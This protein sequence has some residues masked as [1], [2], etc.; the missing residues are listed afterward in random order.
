MKNLK[1]LI[2][3]LILVGFPFA[4]SIAQESF[5]VK[6]IN[7]V[8]GEPIENT[9]ISL[10]ESATLAVSDKEGEASISFDNLPV[11]FT[12]SHVSFHS[13]D[14]LLQ[15]LPD[16]I[17]LIK[18]VPA[19][20]ALKQVNVTGSRYQ[21]YFEKEIFYVNDFEFDDEVVWVTGYP[22]KNITN[23]QL[24]LVTIEGET[25]YSLET[26]RKPSLRKDAFGNIHLICSDSLYQLFF[27]GE[28]VMMLYGKKNK[29]E[30]HDLFDIKLMLG[31][32]AV[33]VVSNSTGTFR[34]FR[35]INLG[36]KE[37]EVI[38][39]S[40]NREL[41]PSKEK[42]QNYDPGPIPNVSASVG[43]NN[44]WVTL[45]NL[46]ASKP[47][48][49][50]L[51]I[52]EIR[53][54]E[55][56]MGRQYIKR[57]IGRDLTV[58]S[59]N[60]YTNYALD[61]LLTFKPIVAQVFSSGKNFYIFEDA[62]LILWEFDKTYELTDAWRLDVNENARDLS[63]TQDLVNEALYISYEINGIYQIGLLDLETGKITKTVTLDGFAFISNIKVH[64]GRIYFTHQT[65]L[66]HRTMNLYSTAY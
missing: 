4:N 21:E 49:Q 53:E 14:V 63:L 46:K 41:F 22:G 29:P 56:D 35:G 36:D 44:E 51:S 17:L 16:E 58:M 3:L 11:V 62:E 19:T 39:C 42:A 2:V 32:T 28:S 47:E 65:P 1:Y 34:E 61:R 18:L 57:S 54:K 12:V 30:Q 60:S 25:I 48:Y 55:S 15:D 10:N 31:D 26:S 37:Y 7:A 6:I 52:S 43:G 23:P 45:S 5:T 50:N 66:G 33:H 20:T 9:Q 8:S 64:E 59:R 13:K 24:R 40:F 38:H 27:T